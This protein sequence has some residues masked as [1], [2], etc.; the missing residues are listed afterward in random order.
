MKIK[1]TL[2]F[3]LLLAG[4][5]PSWNPLYT[6]EDLVF[7]PSLVGIWRPA[8]AEEGSKE[9][10][11]FTKGG[12]K[13]YRLQQT[14]EAGRKADFEARLVRL[15]E[16]RFLDLY[17]CKVEDDDVK[18]NAWAGFSLVPA[19]LILRVEQI[20]PALKIAAIN[21]DWMKK[22][23]KLHPDAIAHRIVLEDN[24]I[25]TASTSDLQ[26]FVLEHADDE[27]FFGGAME[28]KRQAGRRQ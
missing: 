22:F 23:L 9:T 14:D 10:W 6:E 13:L 18:L 3:G 7:D 2:L 26:R 24:V 8:N 20:E 27:G 16:H 4:C 25:L 15:Q 1:F 12:D 28:L 19:H 11:A 21:P 17:L 5:V